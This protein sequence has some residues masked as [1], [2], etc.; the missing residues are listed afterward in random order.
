[1]KSF[2]P[3]LD[4]SSPP[5]NLTHTLLSSLG[6]PLSFYDGGKREEGKEE[7]GRRRK[8]K[9]SRNKERVAEEK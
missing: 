2:F 5:Y 3:D 4:S 9:R 7:E 8:I 1:M 6:L